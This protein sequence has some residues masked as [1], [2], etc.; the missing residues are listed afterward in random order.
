[1]PVKALLLKFNGFATFPRD[2]SQ[3]KQSLL[4]FD[5]TNHLEQIGDAKVSEHLTLD[6]IV[7]LKGASLYLVLFARVL[8]SCAGFTAIIVGS[9]VSRYLS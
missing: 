4:N 8:L 2:L 1:M 3:S 7:N 6:W 5:P 9:N